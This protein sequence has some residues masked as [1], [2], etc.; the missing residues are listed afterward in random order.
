MKCLTEPDRSCRT[1]HIRLASIVQICLVCATLMGSSCTRE[2]S[3]QSVAAQ[4]VAT[5]QPFDAIWER[6]DRPVANGA[7]SR[8]WIWGPQ[9]SAIELVEPYA[10]ASEG[11]REVRYFDKSRMELTHPDNDPES[12]WY[13]TNGLLVVELMTGRRQIGDNEF[14]ARDA[15]SIPVAGD[16]SSA[17]VPT[18]AALSN[19]I[20]LPAGSDGGAIIA[21]VSQA[22]KVVED[23]SL[24]EQ[25]VYAAYRVTVPGIDHHVASVFW[26]FMNATGPVLVDGELQDEHLFSSPFFATGYPLTE[27]YWVNARLGGVDQFILFQAFERRVLTYT[28]SN[29]A[30]WKVES[31][32]VGLHYYEWLYGT[33]ESPAPTPTTTIP[34]PTAIPSATP[35]PEPTVT[36]VPHTPSQI[37][38]VT[39]GDGAVDAWMRSVVR[40]ADDRLW[41]VALDNNRPRT[42]SGPG[43]L[44]MYRATTPGVPVAFDLVESGIIESA[45]G[46]GEIVMADAALDSNQRLHVIWVDRGQ[47]GVPIYYRSFDLATSS[48]ATDAERVDDTGLDGFGGEAGQGGASIA[49]DL[50]GNIRIA[51]VVIGNHTQIRVRERSE[52]HWSAPGEPLRQEGSFVW[53]PVLALGPD[54]TWYLAGYDATLNLIIATRD[55]GQGWSAPDIV[56]DDVLGPESIDQG[57]SCLITP[58]GVPYILY[59]DSGSFLRLRSLRSD[60]WEDIPVGGDYFTHAPGLGIYADGTFIVSG[61]DEFHPPEGMNVM[62]GNASGWSA[63]QQLIKIEADGSAVFRWAGAFST[64]AEDYIDLVFF[65]EDLNDDGL[66]DD[67]ALYYVAIPAASR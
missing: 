49:L 52:N 41:I 43:R 50:Q 44:V 33:A 55:S 17:G 65:D 39:V 35:P 7:V 6:T 22:G 2:Q 36:D 27:A 14:E 48:W 63:W 34:E 42:G 51:Y 19:L 58:G 29:P 15:A 1:G 60:V 25:G 11:R 26:E 62:Y 47:P 30:G 28:P 54:G 20:A 67:Q 16:R 31:G 23:S 45:S 61:H 3:P 53:H 57:P 66:F 56:A 10:D 37:E 64:P 4:A 13:V 46:G 40:D 8:T 24:A 21:L 18:Y 59:V 32:N 38:L 5:V 12:S 9:A